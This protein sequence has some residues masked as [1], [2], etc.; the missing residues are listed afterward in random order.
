LRLAIDTLT[1]DDNEFAVAAGNLRFRMEPRLRAAGIALR[2][3]TRDLP[4]AM[5]LPA[6]HVLPLL[7]VIQEAMTN[8]LKH[9]QAQEIMVRI[10][11]DA[12]ELII[13]IRDDGKGFDRSS[14]RG[15]KGLTGIEKR[16]RKLG[17]KVEILGG[18][19]TQV[20]LVMPLN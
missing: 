15:G 17:A 6:E 1:E 20:L 4:D 5:A 3:N 9:A 11:A 19:G 7:R 14:V 13:E 10:A 18:A 12:N 16:A 8:T 2:W